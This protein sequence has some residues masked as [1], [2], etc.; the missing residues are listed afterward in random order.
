MNGQAFS[1]A[2][3]AFQ[4]AQPTLCPINAHIGKVSSKKRC[5]EADRDCF[6]AQGRTVLD[7]SDFN[8]PDSAPTSRGERSGEISDKE[9]K[10]EGDR[11]EGQK[12]EQNRS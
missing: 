4:A 5:P 3:W 6:D 2:G 9:K 10:M 7:A 8:L 12:E 1:T 11:G